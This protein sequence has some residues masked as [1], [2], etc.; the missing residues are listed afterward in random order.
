MKE[1]RT[2][3][4]P[5]P[6]KENADSPKDMIEYFFPV[7]SEKGTGYVLPLEKISGVLKNQGVATS[8]L[9]QAMAII[10]GIMSSRLG[11][12]VP[13]IV[14]EDEGAG[15][16]ELMQVCLTL[17][18]ESSWIELPTGKVAK[19]AEADFGGKTIICYE[20]DTAKDYLSR[21]LRET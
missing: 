7:K 20:A 5:K 9:C 4:Q 10:I 11:D 8:H 12:P 14:T 21:L 13:M 6:V 3:T 2:P 16:L 15:A 17:V 19:S 1:K 18:P